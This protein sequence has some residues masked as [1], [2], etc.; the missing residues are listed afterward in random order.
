VAA[1][2]AASEA[3]C[4]ADAALV[5]ASVAELAAA[6]ADPSA[7]DAEPA[8]ALA[9]SEAEVALVDAADDAFAEFPALTPAAAALPDA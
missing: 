9:D 2:L 6:F 7:K 4:E 1:L 3:D 8:A 5:A